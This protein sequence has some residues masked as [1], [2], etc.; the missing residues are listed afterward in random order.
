MTDLSC[1]QSVISAANA[2]RSALLI[3]VRSQQLTPVLLLQTD[4]LFDVYEE[5]RGAE[6]ESFAELGCGPAQHSLEMAESG[7]KT[8]CVDISENMLTYAAGLAAEDD[9]TIHCVHQDI[10]DFTLPVRLPCSSP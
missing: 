9:L 6:P 5:L 2:D 1:C 3:R 8:F 10:R 4:F 7:L